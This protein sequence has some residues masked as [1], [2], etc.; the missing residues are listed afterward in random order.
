MGIY[1]Q[2][3]PYTRFLE[4]KAS[5]AQIVKSR[6]SLGSIFLFL[7]SLIF[8]ITTI[9]YSGLSRFSDWSVYL[10]FIFGSASYM[11]LSLAIST[12][13][14][15]GGHLRV[16]KS[17]GLTAF[18]HVNRLGDVWIKYPPITQERLSEE[19]HYH[20][21][22]G[23]YTRW[24][25]YLAFPILAGGWIVIVLYAPPVLDVVLWVIFV[26]YAI[27]IFADICSYITVNFQLADGIIPKIAWF[28]TSRGDIGGITQYHAKMRSE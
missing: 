3:T 12:G 22:I 15:E 17:F 2:L 8:Y 20:I 24:I 18:L 4:V 25:D 23:P 21:G 9:M 19:D 5:L 6:I 26:L 10:L 11:F 13:I 27:K 1:D 14:H 16:V 7:V 28:F